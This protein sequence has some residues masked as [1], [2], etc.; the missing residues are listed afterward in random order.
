MPW[1]F[2]SIS[3]IPESV[4][5]ATATLVSSGEYVTALLTRLRR[6]VR[7]CPLSP[8]ISAPGA[9]MTT[10]SMPRASA[11]GRTSSTAW[12]MTESI[13][14]VA[15]RASGSSPWRRDSSM[16]SLMSEDR[17]VDSTIIRSAK[18]CTLSLS[19]AELRMASARSASAPTGVLSSW[20]TLATKSRRTASTRRSSARS[21]TRTTNVPDDSGATVARR[22]SMPRPSGGRR[23]RISRSWGTPRSAQAW[24]S[25]CTSATASA[26]RR[27]SP[28]ASARGVVRSTLPSA[29]TTSEAIGSAAS[30][31]TTSSDT[32]RP[33]P[34]VNSTG[35][36]ARAGRPAIGPR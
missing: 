8:T 12:A 28:R 18:R 24:M 30:S 21:S 32:G 14:N 10:S 33:A 9:P 27:T 36:E 26:S 11:K 6:A 13:S 25:S 7:T 29:S 17:R 20:L 22:S 16:M 23:T 3:T 34:G 2:T 4:R 19:S 1:S 31:P 35:R 5:A 15:A